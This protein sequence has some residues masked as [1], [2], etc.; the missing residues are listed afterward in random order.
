MDKIKKIYKI[1]NTKNNKIYIGQSNNPKYRFY[2]HMIGHS[3]SKKI[4]EDVEYYGKE[5]FVLEIIE[6]CSNDNFKEREKYWIEYYKTKG[7]SLYNSTKG[8]EEPPSYL[9]EQNPASK[10]TDSQLN[11]VIELLINTELTFEK[12]GE[13]TN[14]SES[15]V[16]RIN[17]GYN[18]T[19][20]GIDYPIRKEN[21][22]D[23]IAN[24][25][26][27]DLI[28]T[29]LPQR[30]IAEK[31]GVSRSMVTM[32]NIGQNH[33]DKNY[34]YPL[35]KEGIFMIPKETKELIAKDLMN[36]EIP[37]KLSK[38]YNIYHTTIYKIKQ[39]VENGEYDYLCK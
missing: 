12:I 14:T 23:K 30:E 28:N 29:K 8:G 36:G 27:N 20:D 25:I 3:S 9:G 11:Q 19:I 21:H 37:Y 34:S 35:R 38:K 6:D 18:R 32:I 31:Y 17:N 5:C 26:I 33:Y 24:F 10:Y 1:T 4:K 16:M 2:Q 22:F 39:S 15:F 7:F 13:I